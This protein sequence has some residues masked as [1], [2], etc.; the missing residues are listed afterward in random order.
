MQGLVQLWLIS[1]MQDEREKLASR[2]GEALSQKR[3]VL[4]DTA[5]LAV[6]TF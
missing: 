2:T 6:F 4:W 3:P 1:V 5:Y